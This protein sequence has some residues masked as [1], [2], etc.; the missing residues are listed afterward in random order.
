MRFTFRFVY[1]M[2]FVFVMFSFVYAENNTCLLCHSAMNYR[3]KTQKG[4]V[5]LGIDETRFSNSVHGFL[6]CNTCHKLYTEN[7]HIPRLKSV[8][9]QIAEIVDSLELKA[10]V[11]PVA[12]SSCIECHGEVYKSYIGSVHGENIMKKRMSDGPSCIDCHGSPHYIVPKNDRLSS[13]NR[14]NVV[15]V[16]GGCHDREDVAKKYGYSLR[17][18]DKYNE[19]IHGKKYRLGHE[20]APTCVDCHGFH[21]VRH[22]DDPLSPIAMKNR[23]VTCGKCHRGATEKFVTAI[24]HKPI[25]KD[26]PIPYYGEK[27]LILL[28]ISVFAFITVH[29]ILEIYSEIRDRI[30][31]K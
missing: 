25:G 1:A 10:K 31:R 13:V 9:P 4:E 30:F 17:I 23:T 24:T 15:K 29:V 20:D 26:N 18:V 8:S 7:P 16:C 5:Y 28:T 6:T 19:S 3:V 22:W 21:D 11:D 27:L 2:V 12:L 14:S